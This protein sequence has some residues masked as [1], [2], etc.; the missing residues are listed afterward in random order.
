MDGHDFYAR[1]SNHAGLEWHGVRQGDVA[2]NDEVLV[3]YK[4]TGAKFAVSLSAIRDHS[5]DEL[6]AVLSG[7]RSPRVMTHLTRIVGYYSHVHN[8]NRSKV[9]ELRDRQKGNYTIPEL[10]RAATPENPPQA[11][12]VA[13]PA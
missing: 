10:L 3:Q 11:A 7:Q 13:V 12:L 4:K 8:W 2:A 1:V 5:W 9:A 6:F